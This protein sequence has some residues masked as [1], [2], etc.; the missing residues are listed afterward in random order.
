MGTNRR[1]PYDGT[2]FGESPRLSDCG[3]CLGAMLENL[4]LKSSRPVSLDI[5]SWRRIIPLGLLVF[6]MHLIAA[7]GKLAVGQRSNQRH[8]PSLDTAHRQQW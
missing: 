6:T 4:P 1:H 8:L 3:L 5:Q 7:I 2:W